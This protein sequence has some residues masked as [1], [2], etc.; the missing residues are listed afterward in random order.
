MKKQFF[1]VGVIAIFGLSAFLLSCSKDEKDE[2]KEWKGCRCTIIDDEGYKETL[3][4]ISAAE[5]KQY[6]ATNCNQVAGLVLAMASDDVV[7]VNCLD[8]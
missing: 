2:K 5:A 7:S 3:D 1:L 4:D 6:G 8:L